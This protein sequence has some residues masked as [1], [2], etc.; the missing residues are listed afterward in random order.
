MLRMIVLSIE[1]SQSSRECFDRWVLLAQALLSVADKAEGCARSIEL[2]LMTV[3]T[4]TVS[5]K[6]WLSRVVTSLV[7]DVATVTTRQ[8]CVLA[9]SKVRELR[10][11]LNGS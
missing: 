8:R 9:R 3:D 10:V 1:A 5:G 2:R 6:P 11:V 7:T 4:L